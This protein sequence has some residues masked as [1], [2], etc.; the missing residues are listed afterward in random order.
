MAT[1]SKPRLKVGKMM[2]GRFGKERATTCSEYEKVLLYD[3]TYVTIAL[4]IALQH[5]FC[6]LK[7][8]MQQ[9]KK[10]NNLTTERTHV[11]GFQSCRLPGGSPG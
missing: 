8:L 1:V 10:C 5:L 9:T 7:Q 4:M 3:V 11:L 2:S 6:F